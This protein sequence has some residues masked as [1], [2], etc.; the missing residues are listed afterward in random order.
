[1]AITETAS[2]TV[3]SVIRMSISDLL[4]SP[5]ADASLSRAS[6][7]AAIVG[8]GAVGGSVSTKA[9]M[10]VDSGQPAGGW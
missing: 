2:A 9:A 6:V 5:L 7:A 4:M 3:P 10:V 1:M 8:G